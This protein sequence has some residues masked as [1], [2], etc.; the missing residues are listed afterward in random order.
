MWKPNESNTTE[1]VANLSKD[2]VLVRNQLIQFIADRANKGSVIALRGP[3]MSGKTSLFHLLQNA[4][5]NP[6]DYPSSAAVAL[7][8]SFGRVAYLG[9][10]SKYDRNETPLDRSPAPDSL[11]IL[12]LVDECTNLYQQFAMGNQSIPFFSDLKGFLGAPRMHCVVVCAFIYKGSEIG[13]SSP[14]T[15]LREILP[16]TSNPCLFFSQEECVQLAQQQGFPDPIA[17]G[18]MLHCTTAG[19]PGMVRAMIEYLALNAPTNLP[20]QYLLLR[21]EFT[22]TIYGQRI[23][24][25]FNLIQSNA[26]VI[27]FAKMLI[28]RV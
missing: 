8:R 24:Q 4:F 7:R 10:P 14:L 25:L 11:P 21:P 28:C 1:G 16:T 3:A 13:A 2:R 15:F 27:Q 5:A 26:N 22:Q 19:H 20:N 23:F 17:I 9:D 12:L 6:T 18:N